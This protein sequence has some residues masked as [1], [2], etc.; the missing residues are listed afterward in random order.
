MKSMYKSQA[1]PEDKR[2]NPI[3]LI[4]LSFV[5]IILVCGLV[6]MASASY[7]NAYYYMGNSLHYISRQLFFAFIGLIAMTITANFDYHNWRKYAWV[8]YF[9][10]ILL[11]LFVFTQ[12]KINDA[13]RWIFVGPINFQPSEIA[14]FS[15]II[16]YAML[17]DCHKK[18]MSSFWY[19][20]LPFALILALPAGL[21]LIEP[22]ISATI[23]I[24]G[25]SAIMIFVGGLSWKLITVS[26]VCGAGAVFAA[27]LIPKIQ[28]RF[29]ERYNIWKDPFIDPQGDGFQTIQSLYAIGSGGLMGTNLGNS[30]Q[31]YLFLPEP[32]NDFVFSIACEELGFIGAILIITLF[33]ALIWRGFTI[34]INA[35]DTF[36][37]MMA[38]GLTIQVGLQAFLNMAVVTNTIPNT[39]ISLPFFSYGGTSLIMLLAQ[40]GIVLN[41]SRNA[42]L[43][44][45]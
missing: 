32:Q 15:I 7:A 30:K 21:I 2:K 3:D 22:H 35:R 6:V 43:E 8:I 29:M 11:L 12:R 44:K 42:A 1:F 28:E 13:R 37:K 34:A 17:L 9:I 14:K 20:I 39:G 5:L 36:G 24:V 41:I 33:I 23:L 16:L 10:S 18:R 25:I 4:F 38:I 26:G 31:K 40:M 27:S 19:G 45:E